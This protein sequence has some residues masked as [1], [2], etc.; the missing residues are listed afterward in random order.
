M[1]YRF[2]TLYLLQSCVFKKA[3][4]SSAL[5]VTYQGD[6]RLEICSNRRCCRRWFITINGKECS[7]PAPIEVAIH[8]GGD[9]NVNLHRPATIDGICSDIPKGNLTVGLS[10]GNCKNWPYD[11]GNAHTCWGSCRLIIEEIPSLQ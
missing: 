2:F 5:R 10:V 9:S 7:S 1:V 6:M 11:E 3:R 8:A 4:S